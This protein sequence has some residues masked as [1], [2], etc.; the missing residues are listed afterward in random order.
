[1]IFIKY[2]IIFL[3]YSSSVF[4]ISV[5][6][7]LISS[8]IVSSS[9]IYWCTT[10]LLNYRDH[11]MVQLVYV[12]EEKCSWC[13]RLSPEVSDSSVELVERLGSLQGFYELV[14]GERRRERWDERGK[15]AR[16]IEREKLK[17][18]SIFLFLTERKEDIKC[19][20]LCST[21]RFSD[22]LKFLTVLLRS[23]L[24]FPFIFI[25]S[26]IYLLSII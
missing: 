18:A 13:A 17:S 1:M 22:S 3:L 4:H 2:S 26:F 21:S 12:Q 15:I 16:K 19:P 20:P 10:V 23:W 6:F 8:E 24:K 11:R 5:F 25:L 9:S 14:Y 7:L